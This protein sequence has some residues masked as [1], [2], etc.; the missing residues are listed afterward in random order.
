MATIPGLN[1]LPGVNLIDIG[2][3]F[4]GWLAIAGI[5]KLIAQRYEGHPAADAYMSLYGS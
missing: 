1:V 5:A 4:F 3:A 2:T